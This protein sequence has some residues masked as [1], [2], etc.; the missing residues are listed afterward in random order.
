MKK[1]Q[2]SVGGLKLTQMQKNKEL[3]AE[4]TQ[5]MVCIKPF[6]SSRLS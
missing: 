3:M 4:Y 2:K 5:R 6:I 1:R